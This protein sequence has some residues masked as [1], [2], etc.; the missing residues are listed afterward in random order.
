[1]AGRAV[2][3]Q[4]GL[5]LVTGGRSDYV[6]V[7]PAAASGCQVHAAEELRDFLRAMTGAELA[8]V[9]D[10]GPL[11]ARAILLG[12]TRH[13]QA[14]LGAAPD[15][16]KLG[17]DGFRIVTRAPHLLL[18]GSPVR[19]TLYAVY[20]LLER[21]GG[22]RWYASFHSVVPRRPDFRLPAID[23]TQ[24]PAFVMREVFWYD[25]FGADFAARSRQNGSRME[26]DDTRGGH[27]RFGAFVHT[28]NRF[29]P[30][31][32]FFGEHP[33]YFSELKGKRVGEHSQLCLT[34]PAVVELMTRRVLEAIRKDPGAKLW[35]V[36][37]ND[38]GNYCTCPACS[39]VDEQE[40]SPSGTMIRFVNQVAEAVEKE[41]PEVWIETLAYQYTR[42][43]PKQAHPRRNV[44]PRLCSIE[45]DFSK[46]LAVSRYEQNQRFVSD[47]QGWAALTDKL[48]V[49]DYT[50][51]FHHYLL[52]HPN[53]AALQ[54]NVQFFRD[55][56]VVGLFEQ[57]A[58]QARHAEFAELRA[59][60]LAKLLWN[61][62]A[63]LA[64]LYDDFFTGYYGAAAEPVRSYFD[65]LQQQVTG[66]EVVLRI[67]HPITAPF[68]PDD[69]LERAAGLWAEAERRVADD[70]DALRRV[71][72]S[73]LPV[74]YTR[75]GRLPAPRVE[76]ATADG[77]IRPLGIDLDYQARAA[78][79]LDRIELGK[80]RISENGLLHDDFLGRL[81]DVTGRLR[82]EPVADGALTAGAS[83]YHGGAVL[84][85][86]RDGVEVLSATGGGVSAVTG[87]GGMLA[88]ARDVFVV[89][90]RKP[91]LLSMER[92]FHDNTSWRRRAT[93]AGGKLRYEAE[94][95]NRKLDP[96]SGELV[97]RAALSLG[98]ADA[99]AIDTGAGWKSLAIA[100]DSTFTTFS[101]DPAAGNG[102]TIACCA[103][104]RAVRVS[105][106]GGELERLVLSCDARTDTVRLL[107]LG[108]R[109]E[110]APRSA[111]GM[112]LE[113]EPLARVDGL[114]QVT[115]P[116]R[117]TAG[118]VVLED[119]YFGTVQTRW[120]EPVADPA[121]ADGYAVKLYNTHF[122]WCLQWA[123]QPELF[124]PGQ[125]YTVRARIRVEVD[126]P[127]GEAFW[128]GVYDKAAK[129]G[130]GQVDVPTKDL[131]DG[132]HWYDLATWEPAAE[133]Y[134]WIGPGRFDLKGGAKS[135]VK[136]VWVD[137]MEF[138]RVD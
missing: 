81:R 1:M 110:V 21:Y 120:G 137:Q 136:G 10:E 95:Q 12:V 113:L 9:T 102:L 138:V 39:A 41:F 70:P 94:L 26:L 53:F 18:L 84:S 76:Y 105:V 56:H 49:W 67:G 122:E 104:G 51:N 99:I 79:V 126:S 86:K 5:D 33:E 52:P 60:V 55:N 93:L 78:D 112:V 16:A 115:R 100:Q 71:K 34:N 85:L 17:D 121:A 129:K 64:A 20:E 124:E 48:Y 32:D 45:C 29:I 108:R 75:F 59:W 36:S 98:P 31:A 28:F 128:A 44:V 47:I 24:V 35:S 74:L 106:S 133:Q 135:S 90:E 116:E 46:P 11:P 25:M 103:G 119:V 38:W 125:R 87:R 82:L 61:P 134:V 54:G 97:L 62:E 22:C 101:L 66:D 57:G 123:V 37:Q 43:P 65:E 15:L 109:A 8:I 96:M 111:G 2:R 127:A 131:A 77:A 92:G 14:V 6:I 130:H 132:Y 80:V 3:A 114:P 7:R 30:P 23:D 63:D 19:G 69:F 50:T 68:L 40:G 13:T 42:H 58:Y 72:L 91:N 73:A 118:K 27:I 88:P 117:H 89:K 4:A 83:A 107:A